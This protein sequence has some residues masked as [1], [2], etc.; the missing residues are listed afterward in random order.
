MSKESALHDAI[1]DVISNGRTFLDSLQKA[2]DILAD[3]KD[4]E[5]KA[6]NVD[7]QHEKA[8]KS[9]TLEDVRGVLAEKS[10]K[11]HTAEVK[12][13]I[14]KFGGNKLSDISPDKYGELLKLAEEL[15]NG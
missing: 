11:G 4:M 13:L 3:N 14:V 12:A 9:Y 2:A 1:M 5:L 15:D 6:N 7:E 8:E 10:Q